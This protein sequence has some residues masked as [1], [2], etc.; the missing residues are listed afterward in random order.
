MKSDYE[1]DLPKEGH[2]C[3]GLFVQHSESTIIGQKVTTGM[4]A[5][6]T[7]ATHN[8]VKTTVHQGLGVNVGM[9][10]RT[11]GIHFAITLQKIIGASLH[12]SVNVIIGS[13]HDCVEMWWDS[14]ELPCDVSFYGVGIEM[15]RKR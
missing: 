7:P 10:N 12:P 1:I 2:D 4:A 11:F 3:I 15:M 5:P 8:L 9:H 6:A 13:C 14:V